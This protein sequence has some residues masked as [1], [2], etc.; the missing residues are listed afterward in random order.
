MAILVYNEIKP[1]K[2]IILEGDPY[3]VLE[4][5]F[6]RVQQMK[7]VAQT[8]IRN[9]ITGRI[10]ERAFRQTEKVEEAEIEKRDIKYLY[11]NRGEFWFT[12]IKDPSKRFKL[13]KT[14]I[15]EDT[16]K[17]LKVNMAVEIVTFEERIIGVNLPIKMELKVT[18]APPSIRGN[19]AQG[20][21]KPV[22]LETGAVVNAPLFIN[23]D[24]IIIVNTQ[25]GEYVSRV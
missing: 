15:N 8:K 12:E 9:L 24:D 25:T 17:F 19:T 3:L 2:Y 6:S 20:G 21:N 11:T 14:E 1:G 7:P 22:T 5:S 13:G 16:A 10:I 23:E 18:E 4:Y